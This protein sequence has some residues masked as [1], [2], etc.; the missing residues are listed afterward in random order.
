MHRIERLDIINDYISRNGK[1]EVSHL[2]EIT[3]VSEATIRRDLALLAS[4]K[5]IVRSHGGAA[6]NEDLLMD[7][8][9]FTLRSAHNVEQKKQIA[10]AA[11]SLIQSGRTYFFDC[12]STVYELA[13][14]ITDQK[15]V[16]VT[17]TM[18]TAIELNRKEHVSV[19]MLG[20]TVSKSTGS[21]AGTFALSMLNII[22]PSIA[23]IGL[24]S[25]M[26]DGSFSVA[27]MHDY[28]IKTALIQQ[29]ESVIVLIDSSKYKNKRCFLKIGDLSKVDVVITDSAIDPSFQALCNSFNCKLIIANK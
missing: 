12:S 27:G 29:A 13:K 8:T 26:E 11:L 23:F 22:Q 6:L 14:L 18:Y 9:P 1:A 25:I 19:V 17:D 24:P 3:N 4:Q 2:S 16:A 20:G 7:E 10:H 21:S 15:I 28:E 5:K